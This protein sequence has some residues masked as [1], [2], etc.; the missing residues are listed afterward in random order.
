MELLNESISESGGKC[1][2]G[3]WFSGD[4]LA[5]RKADFLEAVKSS[6]PLT[7]RISSRRSSVIPA[8]NVSHV[9]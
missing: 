8:S 7:D 9:L 3:R 4:N 1:R 5:K 2:S 6:S